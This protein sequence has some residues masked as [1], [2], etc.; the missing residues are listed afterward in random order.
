MLGSA[1]LLAGFHAGFA[2]LTLSALGAPLVY[3]TAAG[4]ALAACLPLV[5]PWAA[6]LPAAAALAAQG[7]GARAAALL[8]AHVAAAAYAD[9]VILRGVPGSHPYLTGLGVV[10]APPRVLQLLSW[11]GR[12]TCLARRATCGGLVTCSEPYA[13]VVKCCHI[14]CSDGEV[15]QYVLLYLKCFDTTST[16]LD[17]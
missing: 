2:W 6:V 1:L 8:A 9:D 10:G 14:G 5:P 12:L 15:L 4:S 16:S 13:P 3:T 17:L 7:L 11:S